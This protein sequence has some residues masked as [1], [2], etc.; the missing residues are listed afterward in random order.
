M[1]PQAALPPYVLL[2]FIPVGAFSSVKKGKRKVEQ[3]HKKR[4]QLFNK[5][6]PKQK[7][8]T[9]GICAH[10][11]VLV[12]GALIQTDTQENSLFFNPIVQR[13]DKLHSLNPRISLYGQNKMR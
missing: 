7:R 12:K 6:R 9:K 10:P 2:T 13:L 3:Q 1:M 4:K 8:S 5:T 11:A